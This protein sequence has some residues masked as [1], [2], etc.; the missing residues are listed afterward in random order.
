MENINKYNYYITLINMCD[1][2]DD[3]DTLIEESGLSFVNWRIAETIH[4]FERIFV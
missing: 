2:L 1:A 4:S 3:A